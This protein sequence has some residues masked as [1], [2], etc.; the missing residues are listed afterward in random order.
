MSPFIRNSL[1]AVSFFLPGTPS[2]AGYTLGW[3][4]G[5]GR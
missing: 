3:L 5:M 1:M 2:W 4:A